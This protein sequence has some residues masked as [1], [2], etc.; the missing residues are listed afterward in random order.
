MHRDEKGFTL[1]EVLASL[2]LV[3]LLLGVMVSVV[4]NAATLNAKA[5]LRADAGSL[6]FKKVQ[7]YINVDFDSVPIGDDVDAYEVED[8]SAEAEAL[9][10]RNA[11]AYVYV[12]PESDVSTPTTVDV[13]YTQAVSADTAFVSGAEIPSVDHDDATG[14]WYRVWR[15]RDNN[16]SNYTYSRWASDPDDLASPSIDLGS[17]QVV[18]TIRV[19]WGLCGYGANNFRIEAK[20][21]SPNSNSGW[22]TISSG[23]S[24]NGIP[25]YF[26]NHPQDINVSSNSTPYRYWRLYFV[27]AEHHSYAVI[28]ELEA[29][30][31][32]TPGDTVEQN[33]SD[34]SSNPGQLDF[35]SVDLDIT[36]N[37]TKGDQSIGMIFNGVNAEQGSTIDN[38][39][40][41]FVADES[42]SGT[43]SFLITG[44][45]VDNA[46]P[47]VGNYAVDN[48]VDGD[49]SDGSTGTAATVTWNPP[50]WTTGE[51]GPDTR[52]TVTTIIQEIINRVGWVSGNDIALAIQP[53]SS[54]NRR[55][56][57]RLP[58]PQLVVEWTES[59]TTTPGG[60]T[61]DDMDGDADN[62]TLI[63]VTTVIEYDA[64]GKRNKVEY[65]TFIRK[66]GAGD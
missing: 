28:S 50:A 23:H 58:A 45:N 38:A 21:S 5:K 49:S 52:V 66:F 53:I 39:Y 63:R 4:Q 1:V 16:Y 9:N 57:E 12:E 31:P 41:S 42:D 47:W 14:D 20:N 6:A 64:F 60:Y 19:N 62:P 34:A 37:G 30:S 17:A 2:V 29:F 7:D 11:T 8:F 40:L 61:D 25:C 10:L 22:T 13:S 32:G 43:D 24:D 36:Q 56:A 3:S 65:S 51:N 33:G 15:I 48:A 44:A 35:D 59:T 55:V 54:T 18:D 27:D 26:G 46:L